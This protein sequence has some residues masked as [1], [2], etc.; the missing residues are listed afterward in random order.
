M[1][2]TREPKRS[3]GECVVWWALAAAMAAAVGPAGAA[4]G[5][6]A[7]REPDW[8][9]WRGPRRDGICDEKGLL[10]RWPAAGPKLL[11]KVTGLGRGW[12]SPIVCRG[13]LYITGDVGTTLRI[14]AFSLDGKPRWE[15]VNGQ[16]WRR[17]YAGARACCLYDA[18]RLYHMNAHGRVA[19][20]DPNSGKEIWSVDTLERF[21]AKPLRWG[22]SECLLADGDKIIVTPG[23]R[24]AMMAALDKTTGQTVWSS[25]PLGNDDASYASPILFRHAGRRH[26]V[27]CSSQ[28]AFGVDADT[29]KIQWGK[30]RPTRFQAIA[31]TP[32]YH[33]GHVLV[34]SPDGRLSELFRL[35]VEEDATRVE[36]VWL[37][38]MEEMSG[39][40]VH[41]DGRLYGSGYRQVR[42]WRCLDFRSGK[43]LYQKEDL[44]RGAHVLAEGLLYC[45]SQEGEVALL[46][47]GESAFEMVGRFRLVEGRVRDCWAHPVIHHGR[48]Y[49][50]YHD[51]LW[52]FD[53]RAEGKGKPA[54]RP[55]A[56]P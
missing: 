24:K 27:T 41:L 48:L 46:K 26:L 14:F 20:L 39:A 32:L 3:C 17:S 23:G 33:D 15:A 36:P 53:V 16:A 29:G 10:P 56:R 52:C 55:A 11:W 2:R 31:T 25:G 8:P 34:G 44:D 45:V 21:Q 47:P 50:R 30:P 22:H 49:L 40:F 12:S 51:A 54:E 13:T 5:V 38:E 6:I 42:G 37:S 9:Q 7:S 28:Q 4:D 18:G 35:I 19:C 1:D 43:V